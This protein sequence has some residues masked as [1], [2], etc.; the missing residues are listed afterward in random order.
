V[1]I[2]LTRNVDR[3][4]RFYERGNPYVS[5]L[6]S[7]PRIDLDGRRADESMANCRFHRLILVAGAIISLTSYQ[8][9]DS[10]F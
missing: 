1:R 5:G 2:G 4:W 8:I 9:P 10:K 3:R 6:F 7:T